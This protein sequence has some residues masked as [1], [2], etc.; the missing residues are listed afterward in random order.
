M[1]Q[2]SSD[3]AWGI[4]CAALEAFADCDNRKR[5]ADFDGLHVAFFS[6]DDAGSP[7]GPTGSATHGS[8][9]LSG[10]GRL[11]IKD[12]IMPGAA[13]VTMADPAKSYLRLTEVLS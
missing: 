4:H 6:R 9:Y 3:I 8:P 12:S 2:I 1:L 11:I 5:C 10:V 7:D 13:V